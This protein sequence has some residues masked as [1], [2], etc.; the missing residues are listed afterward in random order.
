[1][2]T[3]EATNTE[4]V[5][6]EVA[7]T[8][9]AL[10]TDE[11]PQNSLTQKFTDKEWA[12]LKEFRVRATLPLLHI[13]ERTHV[14]SQPFLPEIFEKAYDG[15]DGVRTTPIVIW[16]VELDPNGKKDAR[17]SVVLMKWLRAR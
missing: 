15:K 17:A 3:V 11:E 10:D 13:R 12:A 8:T 9:P 5:Q 1:M 6:K 7:G 4:P 14:L 2:S 16:G